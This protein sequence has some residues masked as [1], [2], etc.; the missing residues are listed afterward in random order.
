[1]EE[2]TTNKSKF[3]AYGKTGDNLMFVP[4]DI[5]KKMAE[6]WSEPRIRPKSDRVTYRFINYLDETGLLPDNRNGDDSGWRRFSIRDCIY[7]EL[8]SA[9]RDF[10]VKAAYIW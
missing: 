6:I 9:L 3:L 1:M 8:V 4:I 5:R 10:N 7:I 2:T